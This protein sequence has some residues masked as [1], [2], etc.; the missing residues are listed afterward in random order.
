MGVFIYAFLGQAERQEM[1]MDDIRAPRPKRA[2]VARPGQGSVPHVLVWPMG[3]ISLTSSSLCG[4]RDKML[5]PKKSQVN[6]SSGR[7]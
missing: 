7:F 4:S 6:L 1:K 5:K 3:P 2:W